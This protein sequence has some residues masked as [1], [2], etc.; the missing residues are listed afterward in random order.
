MQFPKTYC[1]WR[2]NERK[3]KYQLRTPKT[4]FSVQRFICSRGT[5]GRDKGQ[6]QKIEEEGEGEGSH[7]EGTRVFVP[8]GQRTAFG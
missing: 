3:R 4:K 5:E 8:E 7:G 1:V 2:G 6:R